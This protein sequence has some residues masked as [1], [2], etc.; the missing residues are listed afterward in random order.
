MAVSEVAQIRENIANEYMAATWGL[1]GLA[2]GISR[3]TFITVRLERMGAAQEQLATLVGKQ[4]AGKLLADT[5]VSL[6]E[7]PERE[8]VLDVITHLWGKSE[9]TEYL[10]DMIRA[11]WDTMDYLTTEFGV[12]DTHKIIHAPAFLCVK[13]STS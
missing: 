10:L 8:A 3:H 2:S 11:M 6:P 9:E 5:L 1:C 13:H 4:E 7:Q 12:E